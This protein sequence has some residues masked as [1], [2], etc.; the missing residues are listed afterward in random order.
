MALFLRT[1]VPMD[2]TFMRWWLACVLFLYGAKRLFLGDHGIGAVFGIRKEIRRLR[3]VVD[4]LHT[5]QEDLQAG[6]SPRAERWNE[7]S[8]LPSPWGPLL[9]RSVQDLRSRGAPVIPTLA[10]FRA[11]AEE[12]GAA[13]KTAKARAAQSLGQ[14]GVCL[15]LVP[16][17]GGLLYSFLPEV[18]ARP[19]IW[20]MICLASGLIC[21]L[22]AIWLF[23]LAEAARW[24]GLKGAERT[25]P[26]AALCA[27]ERFLS[28]VRAGNPP[29]IAWAGA[30]EVLSSQA[31]GLAPRWGAQLWSTPGPSDSAPGPFPPDLEA[32]ARS[33][34]KSYRG[35]ASGVALVQAGNAI[36]R[37]AQLSLAE[38]KSCSERVETALAALREDLRSCTEREM[39]T[40]STRAL[41]PL[42]TLVAPALLG[43]LLSAMY[44][45][46]LQMGAEMG[47]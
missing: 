35:C 1:R 31:P 22:A 27:G 37:S 4:L 14:A 43:L 23:K 34:H 42:F 19:A 26:L 17:F 44:L 5:L 45:L 30:Y 24:G 32:S 16:I 25:W 18:S 33:P 6:I 12:H 20:L 15:L 38:G 36:R 39:T 41:I 46:W 7:A 8:A 21:A 29:D 28:L 10:R 2:M 9:G 11:L 3:E 47:L 13:L 40:L